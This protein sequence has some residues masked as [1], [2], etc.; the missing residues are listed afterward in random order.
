MCASC[1]VES[2][3]SKPKEI[4]CPVDPD[5]QF[6]LVIFCWQTWG[7]DKRNALMTAAASVEKKGYV[8]ESLFLLLL[9]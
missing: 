3:V 8:L 5:A 9:F 4:Q 7:D 2:Q 6:S 1:P